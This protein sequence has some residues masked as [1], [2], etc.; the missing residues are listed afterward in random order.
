MRYTRAATVAALMAL[1]ACGWKRTPVPIISDNGSSAL[2]VGTW[3]GEYSSR[4]TG[5]SGSIT[6]EMASEKDTAYCDVVMVP[7]LGTFQTG[8]SEHPA[9]RTMKPESLAQPLKIRFIRLGEGRVSGT[10]DSYLD[11]ECNCQVNTAFEGRIVSADT[12]E[13]TFITR[14]VGVQTSNG[15]WKVKRQAARA[16][17]Q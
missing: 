3:S 12:I 15:T 14:G 11:P 10:L 17:T 9:A 13:G 5:R 16:S 7:K 4:E 6:F 8:A 2:L 1:T